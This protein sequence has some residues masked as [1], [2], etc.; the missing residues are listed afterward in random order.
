MQKLFFLFAPLL[1]AVPVFASADKYV[2][3]FADPVSVVQ[4]ANR[5][6]MNADYSAMTDITEGSERKKT[7]ETLSAIESDG[8]LLERLKQESDQIQGFEIMSTELYTNVSRAVVHTKWT[9]KL[10]QKR[11]SAYDT[12]NDRQ[13]RLTS[14]VY[15]DYLL[16]PFDSRW[17]IIS[18]QTK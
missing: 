1:L 3:D 7:D 8:K 17:K 10:A 4:A 5:M 11:P 9:V 16:K 14:T 13:Q 2:Y 6:L 15:V 12:G 18:K